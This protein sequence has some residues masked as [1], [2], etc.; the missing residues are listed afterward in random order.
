MLSCN[1]EVIVNG[2]SYQAFEGCVVAHAGY[3]SGLLSCKGTPCRLSKAIAIFGGIG[4][5]LFLI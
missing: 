5:V 2:L 3:I 4:L 1:Q